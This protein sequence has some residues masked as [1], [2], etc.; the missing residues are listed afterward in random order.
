[1]KKTTYLLLILLMLA[2]C[3]EEFK[4]PQTVSDEYKSEVV[5]Q[6]RILAG[7]TSVIYVS[8]TTP[9]GE[10]D[11]A[12]IVR[13]AEVTIIG[14]NGY[15]SEMAEYEPL[16]TCYIIDTRE[17]P[18]DTQ[19]AIEVKLDGETYQSEFLTIVDSPDINEVTYQK[20]KEGISIHVTTLA[21]AGQARHYMWS[22]EEDWEIHA[23]LDLIRMA[24]VI[25]YYSN[26]IYTFENPDVNPYYYCWSHTTSRNVNLYSTNELDGNTVKDVKLMEIPISDVRLS[27]IYSILVKQWSLSESAY[28]Y[29]NTL[30]KYTESGGSLFAPMPSEIQGNVTCISDPKKKARGY[31][32]ASTVKEKRLF[33]YQS[34]LKGMGP[35]YE[36]CYVEYPP[37]PLYNTWEKGWEF[38]VTNGG[39]VAVSEKGG[40]HPGAVLYSPEC[41]D[42]RKTKGATK[43]RPD[44]WP[45]NHE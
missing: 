43:Q 18:T 39:Y 28:I 6:G 12:P 34:D 41:F 32:L 35:F 2:S 30:E 36:N 27:Y 13:D 44:F 24:N 38:R 22:Y 31:V 4:I 19:Y 1:M 14:E 20:Q 29:Y 9:F 8:Y 25:P 3:V 26:R 21:E 16:N 15:R 11:M 10:E 5:V 45:N 7:E 17:L 33:I 23:E 37:N 40:I 42:C